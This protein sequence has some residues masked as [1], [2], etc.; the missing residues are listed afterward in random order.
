MGK[1]KKTNTDSNK[2]DKIIQENLLKLVPALLTI[3]LGLKIIRIEDLPSR[4]VQSTLER[5]PDFLKLVFEKDFP[6]GR[7][8][9]MEFESGNETYMERRMLEYLGMLYRRYGIPINQHLIFL[10]NKPSTMKDRI[11]FDGLKFAYRIHNLC[12][13]SYKKFL[14]SDIPE[15]VIL[16][17]LA[18]R[19]DLTPEEFV[20][21]ILHRLVELK[22]DSLATRKFIVQLEIISKMRNL[23]EVAYKKINNMSI[24]FDIT[25]DV[26]FKQGLE[27]GLELGL[28]QGME[29]G[30]EQG[31][32]LKTILGIRRSLQAGIK[33]NDIAFIQEVTTDYVEKVKQELEKEEEIRK[34]LDTKRMKLPTIAK[35]LGVSLLLVKAINKL[36]KDK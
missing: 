18:D 7:I 3:V 29:K 31:L 24:S 2:Y 27:Q 4:K 15:E 21:M 32:E 16:S 6:E 12:E 1:L 22:G 28:E 10:G 11:E 9:H 13:I 19:E 25:T 35:K 34:I 26:R 30:L 20:S 36:S 14:Y 33:L 17:I 8:I 23:Q 5:E